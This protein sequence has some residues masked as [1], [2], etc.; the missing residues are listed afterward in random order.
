MAVQ[1]NAHNGVDPEV[2]RSVVAPLKHLPGALLPVL[3]AIQD[4]FGYIPKEAI[5]LVAQELNL[6]RAEVYGVVTFYHDFR[7]HPPGRHI[8]KICQAEA[9]QALGCVELTDYAK[10]LLAVDFHETTLDGSL[11]LEPVYCLGNCACP[12]SVMLDGRVYGRMTKER[13]KH[14]VE[15]C[16]SST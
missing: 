2:V 14:M 5:G 15:R 16:Q 12:P 3:R 1:G 9:C 4:R 8:L 7:R 11:T 13:L 6:S 10:R